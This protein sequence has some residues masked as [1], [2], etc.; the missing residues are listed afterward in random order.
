MLDILNILNI[1]KD[2]TPNVVATIALKNSYFSNRII[3]LEN[4]YWVEKLIYMK[5]I[6]ITNKASKKDTKLGSIAITQLIIIKI[7]FSV[8]ILLWSFNLQKYNK[9][10]SNIKKPIK[11]AIR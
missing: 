10:C 7:I 5:S 11:F 2:K 4:L 6:I 8:C 1:N 9:N 3:F